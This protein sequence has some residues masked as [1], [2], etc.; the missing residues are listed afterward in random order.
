MK[1]GKTEITRGEAERLHESG[2]FLV[3]G[4]GVWQINFSAAQRCYYGQLLIRESGLTRRGKYK[5]MD[6]AGVNNLLDTV[7]L[8][9]IIK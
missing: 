5:I 6:A 9:D 7:I 1:I 8:I 4:R 3:D 2:L